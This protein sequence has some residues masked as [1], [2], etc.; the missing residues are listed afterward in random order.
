MM[1]YPYT[2]THELNL[3]WIIGIVKDFQKNYS[4]ISEALDK[5]I[6]AITAKGEATEADI[7]ALRVAAGQAIQEYQAAAIR[8]IE[9]AGDTA[10]G[11]LLA[12]STAGIDA[13]Q[14]LVQSL[15]GNSEEMLGQ[16]QI[17]NSILNGTQ[18]EAPTWAQ[19]TYQFNTT[20]QQYE[21]VSAPYNVCSVMMG[22][23]NGR[24]IRII[25][26]NAAQKISAIWW[27]DSYKTI[28]NQAPMGNVLSAEYVFPQNASYFS[29]VLAG[30][31]EINVAQTSVS[32]EWLNTRF[33]DI[34]NLANAEHL[35]LSSI[36]GDTPNLVYIEEADAPGGVLYFKCNGFNV[37][38][39]GTSA[40][41]PYTTMLSQLDVSGVVSAKGVANCIEVPNNNALVFDT[42][43]KM[44][45]F[46][47]RDA[48]RPEHAILMCNAWGR[49]DHMNPTLVNYKML[50]I[51]RRIDEIGVN[52]KNYGATGDGYTDDGPAIQ[53]A[54]ESIKDKGGTVYL[55]DGVYVLKSVQFNASTPSIAS[56]LMLY[57][58]CMLEMSPGAVLKR[59]TV[60]VTHF[61]FT[62]NSANSTGYDGAKNITI[63]GGTIDCNSALSGNCTPINTSH[64]N[65]VIID[66][67]RF[68]NAT[69]AWHYVELNSTKNAVIK[70]CSFGAG[71]N[72]EHVQFDSAGGTGNLGANDGTVCMDIEIHS[73]TFD[74]G[75]SC[76]VGNHTD[77]AHH[78][79]RVH[80]NVFEGGPS[81]RGAID[82]TTAVNRLDAYNNTFRSAVIGVR[83]SNATPD[84]TVH[85]NRFESVSSPYTGGVISY[86]N[87]V[88]GVLV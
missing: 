86:N 14:N 69:G 6:S 52:V 22:G 61:I 32:V 31:N 23:C 70:N 53:R 54:I 37:F 51:Q 25:S 13:I 27:W 44:F 17:I 45:K 60:S 66:G 71:G 7:E 20:T 57:D 2:N 29:I 68:I 73:C 85:D 82:T 35:I 1:P 26:N 16:L 48:V 5:A 56:A 10:E 83:V 3:D 75:A 78:N 9:S 72:T 88:D 58:N 79:V 24:K 34:Q 65:G 15:P 4:G 67:V 28:I 49:G 8:A 59:G 76:G 47:L 38:Y 50:K 62:H 63:R 42:I 33:D 39:D 40:Y 19:G 18:S 21:I 46:V 55:P 87:M 77:A 84:S 30:T 64:A 12:A 81:A 41:V 74:N 11:E 43:S 80:D 36:G